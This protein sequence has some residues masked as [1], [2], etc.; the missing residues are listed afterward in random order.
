MTILAAG[1]VIWRPTPHGI[2]VLLVERTKHQDMTVPKGKLDP[3]ETLPECAVR[4]M[5]EETGIAIHLGAYLGPIDYTLPN[6]QPKSVHYWHTEADPRAVAASEVAPS[7]EIKAL[8]WLPLTQAKHACTYSL[9]VEILERFEANRRGSALDTTAIIALRHGK[10]AAPDWDAVDAQR[11]LTE[12]GRRQ[13]RSIA[14]GLAAF[15]VQRILTSTATRCQQT[16][17]P[18]AKLVGDKPRDTK[19]LS[20]DAFDG[21]TEPV[22]RKVAKAIE[23]GRPTVFCSHAPVIPAIVAAVAID[24]EAEVTQGIRRAATLS[25]AAFSVFHVTKGSNPRLVSYETHQAPA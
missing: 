17:A 18:L 22:R 13:A 1:A 7:G 19:Q 15:G 2:E 8:H 23:K 9:D 12:R 14:P 11:E 21:L 24:T 3:G 25:P 4:E 5:L 20:Q 10:A 16:V 6:G